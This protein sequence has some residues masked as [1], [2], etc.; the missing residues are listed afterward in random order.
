[1]PIDTVDI[2]AGPG[3]LGEGFS[4]V[5]DGEGNRVFNIVNSV[6]EKDFECQTLRLRAFA[7]R[8]IDQGYSNR[9]MEYLA[10]PIEEALEQ[11]RQ[12]FSELWDDAEQEVIKESINQITQVKIVR[13]IQT[14]INPERPLLLI[15]G[16]PCQAYSLA[17]RARNSKRIKENDDNWKNDKRRTLYKRYLY[18]IRKLE[19]DAFVMEN[20]KGMLSATLEDELIFNNVSKDLKSIGRGYTL[21][22]LV[23]NKNPNDL[24]ASD[25]I[26]ESENFGVPQRRHR[27]IILG[28]RKSIAK[29]PGVLVPTWHSVT[30]EESISDLPRLRSSFS[31]REKDCSKD[32]ATWQAYVSSILSSSCGIS[33]AD[34]S[35]DLPDCI[36]GEWVL[37]RG[38]TGHLKEWYRPLEMDGVPNHETRSHIAKDI[39]RYIF[40]ATKAGETG[41]SPKINDFPIDLLPEHKNISSIK[42][43]KEDSHSVDIA[44]SD[45]FRVQLREEP[46]TTITS[47]ISKDGHY[48][49]HYDPKQARSLTVRE[50]ARLQTF[51]DD[52]RFEGSRT[53]QYHQVGN[54]VPPYLA[55]QIAKIVA[56]LL[57][58]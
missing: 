19:P 33:E 3:G 51:P 39:E 48:Y 25:F 29:S 55:Y 56:E 47:H 31:L 21:Y 38:N 1:M 15:G 37:C 58:F 2:F 13:H 50:A 20:V 54:A 32:A 42:E 53:S 57:V 30:V 44:F 6:E 23:T 34:S 24:T 8:L 43:G 18:F 17:G 4:A 49:I 16:P 9:Y 22:S 26:I 40:C 11:L 46:S 10:T 45:R 12:E 52:Y 35:S 41:Y 36:G 14:R 7:R 27:V 5:R 28:V